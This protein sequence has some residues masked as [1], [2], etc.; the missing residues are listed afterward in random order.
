[1]NRTLLPWHS[2]NNRRTD[3][4]GECRTQQ[5]RRR[6]NA[7]VQDN[8]VKQH[9]E[10]EVKIG[11]MH[12]ELVKSHTI[13]TEN[14]AK[15]CGES[16]RC[17]R[18]SSGASP[19]RQSRRC[20]GELREPEGSFQKDTEVIG[21]VMAIVVELEQKM[22]RGAAGGG[23]EAGDQCKKSFL[24]NNGMPPGLKKLAGGRGVHGKPSPRPHP[25]RQPHARELESCKGRVGSPETWWRTTSA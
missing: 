21:K 3:S 12:S 4:L 18:Q 9:T 20:R 15:G 19:R 13:H 11:V 16:L 17:L 14:I 7:E 6:H 23:V 5:S 25:R 22:A 10:F 2:G 24:P 8:L 1:M